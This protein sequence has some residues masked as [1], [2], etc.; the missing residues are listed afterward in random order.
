MKRFFHLA[1]LIG[2]LFGLVGQSAAIAMSP[3]CAM[4]MD[5]PANAQAAKAAMPMASGEMDCCPKAAPAKHDSKSSNE[6]MQG[7]L[8]MSGC[9]MS[10]A[11]DD[12]PLFSSD[13]RLLPVAA[14]WPLATQLS[15]RSV[16]PEQRPPSIQS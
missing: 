12:T 1:L 14:I 11:V 15:G 10:L 13:F 7:C 6:M 4:M 8:M 16:Q 5:A 3:H 2:A 9:F